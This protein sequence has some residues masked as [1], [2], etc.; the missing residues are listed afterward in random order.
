MKDLY[1]VL[2]VSRSASTADIKSAFRKLAKEL[3]PD[4]NPGDTIVAERFKEVSAAN[5]ILGDAKQR[6]RYDRGEID[7]RGQEV[8]GG[9]RG[10]DRARG[11]SRRQGFDAFRQGFSPD[12]IFSEL[13]GRPRSE[14]AQPKAEKGEDRTYGLSVSFLEAAT[15]VKKRLSLKGGKE[16]EVKIPRAVRPGQQIRLKGQGGPGRHGGKPGDALVEITVE[17]HPYFTREGDDIH[18]ELPITLPE[19]V[20]GGRV[21]VPTLSGP[22]TMTIPEGSNTGQVMRL[23]GKGLARGPKNRGSQ[24][25]TLKVVLPDKPDNDLKQMVSRWAARNDYRVRERFDQ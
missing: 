8:G 21:T 10:R 3:H 9:N 2:G 16:L 23:A 11:G 19:A 7:A 20:L 6:R 13:F 5:A 15:G 25:V 12:D 1:Q 24:F 22:V 4:V 14:R 17:P 18:L